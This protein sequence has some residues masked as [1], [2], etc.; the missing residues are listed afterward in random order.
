MK[1]EYEECFDSREVEER[2]TELKEEEEP[3]EEDKEEL[4][5]LEALKE[6]CEGYGWE[7]G[8][9]FIRYSYWQEYAEE[10]FD[11]CYIHSVPEFA[12]NYIDYKKFAENLE[13]DYNL[14]TFR[15]IDFWYREA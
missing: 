10:L 1:Y 8:I 3:T 4:K 12:K 5:E 7:H 2:M 9:T 13:M 14:V 11:E 15:G 6:E